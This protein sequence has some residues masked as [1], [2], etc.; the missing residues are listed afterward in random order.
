MI[1]YMYMYIYVYFTSYIFHHVVANVTTV[2][3][4]SYEEA[5]PALGTRDVRDIYTNCLYMGIL[6]VCQ[7]NPKTSPKRVR[8]HS[9][10]NSRPSYLV[11]NHLAVE[12]SV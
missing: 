2:F 6:H 11:P 8:C 7:T 5:T 1:I 3:V 12:T 10:S 9:D 4:T